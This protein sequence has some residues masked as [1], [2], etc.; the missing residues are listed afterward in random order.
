VKHLGPTITTVQDVVAVPPGRGSRGSWHGEIVRL[1]G[2]F[3][4][5]K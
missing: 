1:V 5:E 4:K 2:E 3:V